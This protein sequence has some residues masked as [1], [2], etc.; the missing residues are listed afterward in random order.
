LLI[1][2]YNIIKIVAPSITFFHHDLRKKGFQYFINLNELNKPI[3]NLIDLSS[4]NTDGSLIKDN[5]FVVGIYLRTYGSA[6]ND[7][8]MYLTIFD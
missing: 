4:N 5:K 2:I 1:Y 3:F 6:N 7:N 8:C